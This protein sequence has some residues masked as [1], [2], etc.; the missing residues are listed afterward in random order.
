MPVWWTFLFVLADGYRA[1]YDIFIHFLKYCFI[2]AVSNT[3]IS[4]IPVYWIKYS[5]LFLSFCLFTVTC[6]S[7]A[8]LND[9]CFSV[10]GHSTLRNF[11][12]LKIRNNVNW[13]YCK[14][15]FIYNSTNDHI[16]QHEWSLVKWSFVPLHKKPC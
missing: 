15:G 7:S 6:P 3:K 9:R 1:I 4:K 2:I 16:Q 12:F 13:S 11:K 8:F 14:H 5:Y 10:L